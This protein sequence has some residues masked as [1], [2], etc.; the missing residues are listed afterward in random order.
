LPDRQRL[1]HNGQKPRSTLLDRDPAGNTATD[2]LMVA[3]RFRKAVEQ[4][5]GRPASR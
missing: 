5:G 3:E 1:S 4:F 2:A